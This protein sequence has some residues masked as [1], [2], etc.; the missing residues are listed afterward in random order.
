MRNTENVC[1]DTK[2]N[3]TCSPYI[4]ACID[5]SAAIEVAA[6]KFLKDQLL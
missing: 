2:L 5:D 1:F 4:V 6:N 3:K